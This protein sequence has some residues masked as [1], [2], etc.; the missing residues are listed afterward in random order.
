LVL[1]NGSRFPDYESFAVFNPL[2]L[3]A[4]APIFAWNR[5]DATRAKLLAHYAD[6]DVWTMERDSGGGF[7]ARRFERQP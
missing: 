6:R 4:D 3:E 7:E 5:D 2:D 1:V